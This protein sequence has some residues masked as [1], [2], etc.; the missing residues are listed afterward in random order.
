MAKPALSEIE[1]QFSALTPE[2]QLS[3][4]ERLVHRTRLA[5]TGSREAWETNL[6]AMAAD[7]Q[8]QRELSRINAEFVI[9]EADGLETR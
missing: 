1:R 5:V 9:A 6:T 2:A 4:L 3:L 8:I 7:P